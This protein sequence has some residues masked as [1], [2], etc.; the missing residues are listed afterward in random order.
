M[1]L[2]RFDY[3]RVERYVFFSAL[4]RENG[5]ILRWVAPVFPSFLSAGNVADTVVL[6]FIPLSLLRLWRQTVT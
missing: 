4:G 1:L 2:Q 5:T 3:Q 6:L